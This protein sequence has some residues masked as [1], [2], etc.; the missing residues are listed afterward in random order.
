[1]NTAFAITLVA[2]AATPAAVGTPTPIPDA[3][4]ILQRSERAWH[5]L[6]S[7]QVPVTINGS[8][9]VSIIS[10]PVR[11]TGTQYYEAPDRQAL[12]LNNPPRLAAG[13]GNTLSTMGTPQTWLQDYA[14]AAPTTQPHGS[15]T[16]YVLVGTPKRESRVKTMTIW[17]S[18]TTYA[19]ESVIFAYTNGARLQVTF[20]HHPGIT[21]YHLPRTANITANFPSYRG[22]AT[23]TYGAYVLN[24]PIPQSVFGQH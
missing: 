16:A 20:V 8:V 21:Q 19:L 11:M 5:G 3:A 13:L 23:I 6:A 22:N 10:L 4:T 18:A 1:M 17:V 24:Q 7:Y 15:H 2:V 9:R 14:I 12:H